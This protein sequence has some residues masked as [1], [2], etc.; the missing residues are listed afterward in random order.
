MLAD[1]VDEVAG[2]GVGEA[3]R[4]GSHF[5]HPGKEGLLLVP[6]CLGSGVRGRRT[7]AGL[8]GGVDGGNLVRFFRFAL[9]VGVLGA[10]VVRARGAREQAGVPERAAPVGV[11][12]LAGH[13]PLPMPLD[14]RAVPL[15]RDGECFDGREQL[16]LQPHHEQSGCRPR[17]CRPVLEAFLPQTTVLVEEAGEGK[18]RRILGQ[19]VDPNGLH[20]P[21]REAA[22]DFADVLLD[23]PDHHCFERALSPDRHPPGKAV[24]IEELQQ[25]GEAVRVAVVG[26]RGEEQTV[27]ETPP[28]IADRTR[29][30]RLDSVPPAARRGRVVGFVQDQQAPREPLAQPLTHGVGVGRVDEQVV[31]YE[32]AAVGAPRVDSETPFLPDAC[33]VR[34]VEDH[35]EEAEAFLHLSLPLLQH[36]RGR[37]DRDRPRLLSKQ[38]LAGDET[39]FDGLAEAGVVGDE[40]VDA[41][42]SER[43]SE[44]L[45]LVGVNLDARPERRLEE[46][47]IG[48]GDA[49]PAQGVQEGAEV[50]W[51]VEAPGADGAPRFLLEDPAVDL[52]VPV[53]LQG[54]PLG[55]VV[56]AREAD[57]R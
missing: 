47:R 28:E 23:A 16:L 37:D 53:D 2:L 12:C 34:T 49:V 18:L 36:G 19:A 48:R 25:G 46:V 54:L 56:R 20:L 31:R 32:K 6:D 1:P 7:G 17:A 44:R 24:R 11:G 55:I 13:R 41:R 30:L 10:L 3:P 33:E 52:E 51:W 15:E 42:H 5:L 38:Q 45:H 39:R 14:G 35:E 57:A 26:R 29:E 50:A 22:L 27:L 21:L 40:E 8:G 43:L 9:F 4:G